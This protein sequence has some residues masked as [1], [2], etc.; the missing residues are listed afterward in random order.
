MYVYVSPFSQMPM[1]I[2]INTKRA[3]RRTEVLRPF[4]PKIANLSSPPQKKRH[5][6]S[7]P[8]EMRRAQLPFST[9]T[10]SVSGKGYEDDSF[11]AE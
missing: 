11:D 10:L 2:T 9:S 5:Q 3:A 7:H 6:V 4:L 8:Y 1:F